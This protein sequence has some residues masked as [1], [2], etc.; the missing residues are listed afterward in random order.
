MRTRSRRCTRRGGHRS[1]QCRRGGNGRGLHSGDVWFGDGARIAPVEVQRREN[2]RQASAVD[3]SGDAGQR[4]DGAGGDGRETGTSTPSTPRT[5]LRSRSPGREVAAT[6]GELV[7]VRRDD[8]GV[9]DGVRRHVLVV[10]RGPARHLGT[11]RPRHGLA[12]RVDLTCPG[13]EQV[14]QCLLAGAALQVVV[15]FAGRGLDNGPQPG[16]AQGG[17]AAR[18]R[19]GNR[20]AA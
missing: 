5:A 19:G 15:T 1:G 8:V 17:D 3:G 13:G 10:C 4:D 9:D 6:S 2:G 7:P 20:R 14:A 12:G 18:L 11:R 16:G